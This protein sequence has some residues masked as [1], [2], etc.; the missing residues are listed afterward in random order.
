M[1]KMRKSTDSYKKSI[2]ILSINIRE[3][4]VQLTRPVGNDGAAVRLDDGS[5]LCRIEGTR[6]EPA[7]KLVVPDAVVSWF[8][9]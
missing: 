4:C 9:A 6:S 2:I 8:E 7:G 1:H 5:H 3:S